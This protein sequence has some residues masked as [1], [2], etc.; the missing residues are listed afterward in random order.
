MKTR[1]N[2]RGTPFAILSRKGIT[3]Y[4]G[5]VSRI[6][7]LRDFQRFWRYSSG[8]RG[9]QEV[10][11]FFCVGWAI[12]AM[13]CRKRKQTHKQNRRKSRNNIYVFLCRSILRMEYCLHELGRQEEK[14]KDA[15]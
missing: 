3:R 11:F 4:G 14:K 8:V 10:V 9:G 6:G 12:V 1:Q 7:P 5:G 2:G 15:R 13:S